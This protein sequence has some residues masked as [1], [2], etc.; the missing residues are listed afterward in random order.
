MSENEILIDGVG[1]GDLILGV[2]IGALELPDHE[3]M[4]RRIPSSSF[5]PPDFENKRY[6]DDAVKIAEE[7]VDAMQAD[8]ENAFQSGTC[9]FWT[10]SIWLT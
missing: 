1:W 10:H 7:I 8:G 4:E 3:Y 6:L 5:Q 2:V 9:S